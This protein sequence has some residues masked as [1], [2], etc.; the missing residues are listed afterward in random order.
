MKILKNELSR[1]RRENNRLEETIENEKS[2][3]EL[4]EM[5]G[6][7][8]ASPISEFQ[9]EVVRKDLIGMALEADRE[10]RVLTD[11][12]GVEPE[13]FC[14]E[15]AE[16]TESGEAV[17]EHFV[18]RPEDCAGIFCSFMRWNICSGREHR[19]NGEFLPG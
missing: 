17:K 11:K 7:L 14:D 13:V 2:R 19:K 1:L 8:A 12:L 4:Q 5:T 15:I 16:N 10:E 9:I 18:L 3:I 6:Y